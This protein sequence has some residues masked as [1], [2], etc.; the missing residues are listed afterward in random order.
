MENGMSDDFFRFFLD[1]GTFRMSARL[2]KQAK[3]N[4]EALEKYLFGRKHYEF[5]Y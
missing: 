1:F 3:H 4:T 2:K 5:E